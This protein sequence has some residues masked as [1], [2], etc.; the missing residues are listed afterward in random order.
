[1]ETFVRCEEVVEARCKFIKCV[2]YLE[3]KPFEYTNDTDDTSEDFRCTKKM[4]CVDAGCDVQCVLIN[5]S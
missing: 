4:Y 5:E 1:M 2:H 3:H